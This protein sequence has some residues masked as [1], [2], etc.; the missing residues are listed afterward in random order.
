MPKKPK[1][2][3]IKTSKNN[4][5][6]N[7]ISFAKDK[8]DALDSQISDTSFC[9]DKSCELNDS[10]YESSNKLFS[11]FDLYKLIINCMMC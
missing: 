2:D 4:E 11:I 3:N 10:I 6:K 8:S 7:N 1:S 9:M 5:E